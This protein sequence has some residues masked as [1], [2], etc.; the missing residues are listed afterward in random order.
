MNNGP[1]HLHKNDRTTQI[2]DKSLKELKTLTESGFIDSKLHY[3]LKPADLPV[4]RLY[5]QSK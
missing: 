4:H 5:G 3:H 1:Y 2:K